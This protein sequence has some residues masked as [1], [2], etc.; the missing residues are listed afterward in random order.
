M[1]MSVEEE[2]VINMGIPGSKLVEKGISFCVWN[3]KHY[4]NCA[5]ANKVAEEVDA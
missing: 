3:G 2:P 4:V 5:R 1:Y